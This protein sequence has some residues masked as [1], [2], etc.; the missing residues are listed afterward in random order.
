MRAVLARAEAGDHP[1][2]RDDASVPLALAEVVEAALDR[3]PARRPRDPGALAAGLRASVGAPLVVLPGIAEAVTVPVDDEDAA[4]G[5]VAGHPSDDANRL[6]SEQPVA[7]APSDPARGTRAFGPRPPR[8]DPTE[9]PRRPL[10]TG[11][12]VLALLVG[13]VGAGVWLRARL[14]AEQATTSVAVDGRAEPRGAECAAFA[15]IDVPPGAEELTADFAGDGC[16]TQVVWDGQ[17][18]RFR[19]DAS[20]SRPRSYQVAAEGGP[21]QLVIG[22][23]DCDGADTPA[24]YQPGTG[25]VAYFSEVP[26]REGGEVEARTEDSG[27]VEG[28]A[29]L[30]VGQ[31]GDCDR[32][33]VVAEA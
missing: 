3:D 28:R 18:M 24:F 5:V 17:V 22:D 7:E 32:V 30:V 26:E 23:W 13:A 21:G 9:A 1:S 14:G 16:P 19:A 27:V 12:I 33:E 10:V 15:P 2:L 11:L 29:E 25:R 31:D 4:E 6:P 20:E 8:P